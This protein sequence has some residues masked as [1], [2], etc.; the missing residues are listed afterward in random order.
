MPDLMNSLIKREF[1]LSWKND[2]IQSILA[3]GAVFIG[4][5]FFSILFFNP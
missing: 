5:Y 2:V 1:R 4:I 3:T